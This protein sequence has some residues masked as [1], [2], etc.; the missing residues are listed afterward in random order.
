MKIIHIIPSL[1][2]GGAESLVKDIC[3][4]IYKRTPHKI[5]LITFSQEYEYENNLPFHIHIESFFNPSISSKSIHSTGRL[6]KFIDDFRPEIIHSHLWMSEMLLTKINIKEARR[7][8][9]FHDNIP[10]LSTNRTSIHKQGLI[11]LYEKRLF[12]KNNEN[13]FIC[14]SKDT[15]K[16]AKKV[17]PKKYITKIHLIPNGIK[18]NKFL[19]DKERELDAINLI[20]IGSFVPKKNQKFALKIL[21][22]LIERGY[23][24]KIIF[25]GDGPEF[26]NVK[27]FA[28]S[29]NLL[30][31]VYF[32]GN[33][34]DVRPFL[35][36]SNILLHTAYYEPFGL[37]ILEAMASGIPVITLDGKGNRD[38][39]LHEINGFIF[40]NQNAE[41]FGNALIKMKENPNEYLR[42]VKEG[43]KFSLNF[44]I[45]K[46][47]ER[48]VNYYTLVRKR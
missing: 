27:K 2:K 17:L 8:S 35:S 14:I 40:Q 36:T 12:L 9:H 28:E 43:Q 37:V 48:L 6:Q 18:V 47:I 5:K 3:E 7:F 21:K 26:Q 29:L 23:R 39:I 34:H 33:V 13:Q 19:S 31:H 11:N 15:M 4:E 30:K 25:L 10:Q 45:S 1:G 44:D 16:Y 42:Y 38:I 32:K 24:A 41:Q 22:V 46:Y 20:N